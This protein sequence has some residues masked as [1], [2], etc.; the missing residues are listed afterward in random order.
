MTSAAG[1]SI[2]QMYAS[3]M[4]AAPNAPPPP[5]PLLPK[6]TRPLHATFTLNL[7]EQMLLMV[8]GAISTAPQSRA[9]QSQLVPWSV[10][11]S[12]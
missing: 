6:H 7:V 11:M 12:R 9:V 3:E 10:G 4:F 8:Q 2:T 1:Q 5:P